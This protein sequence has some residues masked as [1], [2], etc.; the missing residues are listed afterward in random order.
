MKRSL[1]WCGTK[2]AVDWSSTLMPATGISKREVCIQIIIIMYQDRGCMG[3][4][5]IIIIIHRA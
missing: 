1:R 4:H 5:N 3:V 2:A